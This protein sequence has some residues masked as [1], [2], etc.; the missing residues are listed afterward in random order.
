MDADTRAA[1]AALNAEYA[2]FLHQQNE[3]VLA[4]LGFP[5]REDAHREVLAALRRAVTLH[6]TE[7]HAVDYVR[8]NL[9]YTTGPVTRQA[10]EH[11]EGLVKNSPESA[12]ARR[13]LALVLQREAEHEKD[14]FKQIRALRALRDTVRAGLELLKQPGGAP[15]EADREALTRELSTVQSSWRSLVQT[16]SERG[17]DLA[18]KQSNY[19]EALE[20]SLSFW[21]LDLFTASRI[22]GYSCWR[23]GQLAL[24]REKY[25]A[26]VRN[27]E[28]PTAADEVA[29][30]TEHLL[31][32]NELTARGEPDKPTTQE[33]GDFAEALADRAGKLDPQ[34]HAVFYGAAHGAAGLAWAMAENQLDRKD[35]ARRKA[36]WLKISAYLEKACRTYPTSSFN[37]D[38][39]LVY[40]Y[41]AY[42][43]GTEVG[44]KESA[45]ACDQ[46]AAFL[47]EVINT[48]SPYYG[49]L[50]QL[51]KVEEAT[52]L[53]QS[54]G[55]LRKKLPQE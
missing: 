31:V 36:A 3:A 14:T 6:R 17:K 26:G 43:L 39:R 47:K 8:L 9:E 37:A 38:W 53:I 32:L 54:L 22:A 18:W 40:G 35:L 7:E 23:T 4:E 41:N 20:W 15:T 13:W 55:E 11:A 33:L 10:Q 12:S 24:S 29:L 50:Q 51:G 46:A 19:Y 16:A 21:K 52:T 42:T 44:D 34:T 1:A 28:A 45:A 25:E 2:R 30:R 49:R 5:S 48:K 27:S